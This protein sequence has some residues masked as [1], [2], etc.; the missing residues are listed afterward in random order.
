MP[1]SK[2][3]TQVDKM[4]RN[5]RTEADTNVVERQ[6]QGKAEQ[7]RQEAKPNAPTGQRPDP[8]IRTLGK[9]RIKDRA[10]VREYQRIG[11]VTVGIDANG[12]VATVDF[13]GA[14]VETD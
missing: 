4:P 6:E 5:T 1:E 14:E 9:V 11:E 13:G 10:D 7:G 12:Q 2:N 3:N 8:G